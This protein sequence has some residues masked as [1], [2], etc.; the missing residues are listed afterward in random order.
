LLLPFLVGSIPFAFFGGTLKIEKDVFEVILFVVL[1]I[2]GLLLLSNNKSYKNND[3]H[4]KKLNSLISFI[5][6]SV[7]GLISGIVGIGGGIFLSPILFLMR[8]SRPK[9][10]VT[11]ASV[12]ILI[13]SI[14]GIMGQF[15][16]TQ[17]VNE[18]GNYWY[19]FAI[20]LLGG[21]IGNFINLKFIP[22]RILA[23]I[24]SCLVIFVS[25]RVGFKIL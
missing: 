11:S 13:N 14:S 9:F 20:V 19:L 3:L 5:I 1:L 23:F 16:K 12:F 2:A 25:L 7:I 17:V 21:L 4:I 24:T 22:T 10:I 6:G 18:I 15:T 8:A